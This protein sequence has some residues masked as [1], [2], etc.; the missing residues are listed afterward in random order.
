MIWRLMLVGSPTVVLL[1]IPGIL[2]GRILMELARKMRREYQKVG[3][4]VEQCVST[5]RTVYSF[6]E[7]ERTITMFYATL[8]DSVKLGLCQGLTKGLDV[9]SNGIIFAI[10][11]FLVWFCSRIVM[12]NGGKGG[13]VFAV[14]RRVPKIDS[15][16]SNG[17]VLENLSG[18]VEFRNVEFTYPSRPDNYI[19][20]DF[21][22]N[23]P[24]GRTVALV[25]G[26]GSGKSTVIALLERFAGE[27]LLDG[28]DIKRLQLKW[29]RSQIG[30][31]SQE[32]ALF[33]TSIKENILFGKEDAT[34]EV[35]VAAAMAA[36][37]H[38]FISLLPQGYDTKVGERGAQMSSGQKQRIAI[39][40]AVLKSPKILLLDEATSALDSES[41]R[42]V[43]EALDLT[44]VGRTTIVVAHRLSTIR[45]AD[46]IAVVQ[47]DRV[48]EIGSH[49]H[50]ITPLRRPLLLTR[51]T[52][53]ST[54]QLGISSSV[55][56][57][58]SAA[59][60]N[61]SNRSIALASP[62]ENAEDSTGMQRLPVPSF[63]RLL[64]LNAPEWRQA[65]L[66]SGSTIVFSAIQ[67][68][69]SY[70]LGSM[71]SVFFLEDQEEIKN[72]TRTYAFVFLALSLLSFIL[73][74]GQHYNFGA[75]GESLTKR[76][77]LRMLSK[78]LTF[79]PIIILCFYSR[80]VLLKRL[81][82]KAN[83]SQI[84]SSKLAADAVANL[85]T[86]TAFSP[87]ER[88]LH[89]FEEA[90]AGVRKLIAGGF[91]SAKALFQ[92]FI[93][94]VSIGCI[95]GEAGS[96]T[97]D[98]AKGV[99]AIASVFA[100]LDRVTAIEPNDSNDHCPERIVGDIE[101][102]GVDFAYPAHPDV[103][104]LRAFSLGIE[105]G[106]ST[107]LVGQSGSGK[108]TIIGLIH[109]FYN[110][111][112]GTIKI[113]G[114]VLK[115]YNLRALRKYIGM[116]GQEPTL[117]AGSIRENITYGSNDEKTLTVIEAAAR[118]TNAHEFISSLMDGY[119]MQCG[120]RGLQ[121]SG[122]QKQRITIARA[123]LK[124]PAIL[125][126]DE[127]TSAL[128]RQSKE[129]VQ[130]ALESLMVGRT[131][132][133]VA[134][135]LSTIRHF[136]LISVLDQGAV[137]ENET[138]AS[139]MSKGPGGAYF[140]LITL[141]SGGGASIFKID[142]AAG[143]QKS[144]AAVQAL[145]L[146][147]GSIGSESSLETA[148][149][150]ETESLKTILTG[151]PQNK[152]GRLALVDTLPK[153]IWSRMKLRLPNRLSGLLVN[154]MKSSL[155]LLLP[156]GAELQALEFLLLVISLLFLLLNLNTHL[157]WHFGEIR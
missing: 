118:A 9:D 110:P 20:P 123:I 12:Y 129:A 86:I 131:S 121:L 112:R 95:I 154:P 4:V 30:L 88:I 114:R 34:M 111:V 65:L 138:H 115:S 134:H 1:V 89:M 116:V 135:R 81:S 31:V 72:K 119:E 117:F 15:G 96:M 10:M 77:R 105:D 47:D 102:H 157:N 155:L 56:S 97:T 109:R 69:Y 48:S 74:I 103:V 75:M 24:A 153:Q 5:I 67:P 148:W 44:S 64:Q 124:D 11:A 70:T 18:D 139:L 73:N 83:K 52:G 142:Q 146:Q 55:N 43:Q 141:Q 122:G 66:G 126:L 51:E 93:I 101:I 23:L 106:K 76:I 8:E 33:A 94:L 149:R 84:D 156:Y 42:I 41:E 150:A 68:T 29:L 82:S 49:D 78:I 54:V 3:T 133:V 127:A 80:R 136:H 17:E 39:A 38:S 60:P 63:P 46:V 125:L 27:I 147:H 151:A 107:T 50:L 137:V 152:L 32:P 92:T 7:E 13:T 62:E 99:D 35:V 90:Q 36:N 108:S 57:C 25:G 26:S 40:R 53:S 98:L 144:L 58:F 128:D 87:Q 143:D 61:S 100:V 79:E 130:A 120:D 22:L 85:L 91:I 45:H 16:S 104:I 113:D 21:N 28:T 2:Y 132:V 19:F 6:V 71:I 37:A 145:L 59:S 14:I 140:G